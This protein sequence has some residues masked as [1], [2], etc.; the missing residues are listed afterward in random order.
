MIELLGTTVDKFTFRVDLAL[1]E[2]GVWVRVKGQR[3]RLG[4]SDY[5]LQRSGDIAFV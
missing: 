3:A 1:F 4:L 5:L 2:D